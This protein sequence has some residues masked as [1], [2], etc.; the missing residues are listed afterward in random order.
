MPITLATTY[1]A[2]TLGLGAVGDG[3]ALVLAGGAARLVYSEADMNRAM[4]LSLGT[5][6]AG[7]SGYVALQSLSEP[8]PPGNLDPGRAI[9]F[10]VV[11]TLVRA[12]VFDS[13]LGVMTSTV[14]DATGTPGAA[15]A[16]T[17]S[18]GA[19]QGVETFV[20]MGGATGD[21]AVLSKWNTGGLQVFHLN[22]NGALTFSDQ[23]SDDAKSYVANVSDT[24]SV[25]LGGQNYL[26]TL[27]SLENGITSY[28]IG[29]DGKADLVDSLGNRDLL[30]VNGPAALQVLTVAGVTYA[31][32]AA[33]NSSS[34]SVI[35]VNAM[36]CLFQTDHVVDDLTTRFYHTAVLD[37]FVLNG[38]SFVVTAGSDAGITVLELLPGGRLSPFATGVFE[39]GAGLAAVT[40]LE[41]AVSGTMVSILVVDARADRV[42]SFE[43]SL[44]DLG[45][46]VRPVGGFATGTVKDDRVL[47]GAGAETLQ[48]GAGDDWLHS[49]GGA[50]VMTGGSG[51]D[52][53]VFAAGSDALRITD[54]ELH[55]DRIDLSDWGR[56]YTRDALTISATAD[57]A[58]ISLNGRDV[59]L[60]AGR[61]LTA[62]D[63][64]DSDF[65]F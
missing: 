58:V 36:G 57:G 18:I 8:S 44:A 6:S 48:G 16:V 9:A 32:I 5:V 17:T 30:A 41:V 7:G 64:A 51:A 12:F 34:L 35:R 56:V 42:Q 3:L 33:T 38:R 59:T 23:I 37:S 28:A 24:A 27:S 49:G 62:A 52:C 20:V 65:V 55:V 2:A 13:R 25:T 46:V 50:D 54:F 11:G 61:S 4:S 1:A 10:Q 22:A 45:Q 43:M 47:G 21:C 29:D 26:L 15:Q 31:V 19:L 40:G 60:E 53:F 14:L 63:F 39:T